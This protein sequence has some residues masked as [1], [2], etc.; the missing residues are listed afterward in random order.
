MPA[1]VEMLVPEGGGNSAMF[2]GL[3]NLLYYCSHFTEE[4]IKPLK[5]IELAPDQS[6]T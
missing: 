5:Y 6:Q 3:Q 2:H 1:A 4:N